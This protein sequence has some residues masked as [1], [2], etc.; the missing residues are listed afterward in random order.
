MGVG[1]PGVQG[2]QTGFDA[3]A[4]QA[5]HQGRLE[6]EREVEGGQRRG[7][8]NAE[9]EQAR[10][11][12][13]RAAR[14]HHVIF[15]TGLIGRAPPLVH[16]QEVGSEGHQFPVAVHGRRIRRGDDARQG[17]EGQQQEKPVPALAPVVDVAQRVDA[18][19]QGHQGDHYQE[20]PGQGRAGNDADRR[21]GQSREKNGDLRGRAQAQ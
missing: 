15:E 20:E 6:P 3:E 17:G 4:R 14:A 9:D 8:K 21:E 18:D 13:Q 11:H 10:Q 1:Q 19:H 7:G 2:H 12:E 5:E 16:D